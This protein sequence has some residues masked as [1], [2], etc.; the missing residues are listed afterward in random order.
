ML[1]SIRG[2]TV[3]PSPPRRGCAGAQHA[4]DP[5]VPS[6]RVRACHAQVLL[7][8]APCVQL[9]HRGTRARNGSVCARFSLGGA[10][11]HQMAA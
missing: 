10:A 8:A 5:V 6:T 2:R 7:T 3:H 1:Q 4:P 11:H 9:Q